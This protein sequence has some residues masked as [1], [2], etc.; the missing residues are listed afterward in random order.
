[1]RNHSCCVESDQVDLQSSDFV[2]FPSLAEWFLSALFTVITDANQI[3]RKFD[4]NRSQKGV[5]ETLI[6]LIALMLA[7]IVEDL[8]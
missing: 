5:Q 1:M 8:L 7:C 4:T 6:D 3:H 2:R